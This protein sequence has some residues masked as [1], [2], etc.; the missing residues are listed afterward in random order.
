MGGEG[1]EERAGGEVARASLLLM[2][3]GGRATH[4]LV[5]LRE[6][7]IPAAAAG[8]GVRL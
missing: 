8:V 2:L 5:P 6:R 3:R 1:G 7:I 4:H